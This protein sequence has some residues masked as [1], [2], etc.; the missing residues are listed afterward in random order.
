ML[1]IFSKWLGATAASS[2]IQN[3]TWIIPIV[4]TIHILAIAIVLSSVGMLDLRLLGLAGK[5][6][7]ISGMAERFLP[8]IWGALVVLASTGAILITGEPDRSLLNPAFQIKMALVVA[9]IVVTLIFQHTVRRNAA[10]WDLS[11]ARRRSARLTALISLAIW[12][13]IAICGRLIA[14]VGQDA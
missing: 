12:L 13:A 3:V 10:F 6:V 5:R 8:W 1:Q 7:T 9:A 14:Y 4:Q 11:P 2:F